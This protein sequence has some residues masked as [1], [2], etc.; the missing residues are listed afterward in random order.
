LNFKIA[1]AIP[2]TTFWII[3]VKLI[4]AIG[5]EMGWITPGATAAEM[6]N[7]DDG[8]A[9]RSADAINLFHKPDIIR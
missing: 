8:D 9:I 5:A 1:L 6:W 7:P 4:V 3:I 2:I